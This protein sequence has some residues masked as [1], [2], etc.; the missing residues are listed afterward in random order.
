MTGKQRPQC[1][2]VTY[3][4]MI[5]RIKQRVSLQNMEET[6]E[7]AILNNFRYLF[8]SSFPKVAQ[9]RAVTGCSTYAWVGHW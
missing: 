3:S 1:F 8:R 5:C 6:A 4:A 9:P 2:P 7:C